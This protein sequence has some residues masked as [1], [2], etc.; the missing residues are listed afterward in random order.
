MSVTV[1]PIVQ[2]ARTYITSVDGVEI[3]SLEWSERTHEPPDAPLV[4]A[5]QTAGEAVLDKR[6][7]AR[8]ATGGGDAKTL[9]QQAIST[10]EFALGTQTAHAVDKRMT[11]TALSQTAKIYG[12]IPLLWS[13]K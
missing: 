4:T 7:F 11:V 3:A 1:E 2:R 10:V 9:R 5:V 13:E 6:L 8:S 12:A